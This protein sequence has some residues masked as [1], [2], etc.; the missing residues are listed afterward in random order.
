[1][2][3]PEEFLNFLSQNDLSADIYDDQDLIERYICLCPG[4]DVELDEILADFPSGVEKVTESPVTFYRLA[5]P[6]P[7]N[8]VN[9][10]V[11][12]Q[13]S[14]LIALDLASGMAVKYLEIKHG[15]HVLDLCCAPG[16]KLVLAGFLAGSTGS[17]TG[18]DISPH[19]I[20]T[21]R[22]IVKKYKLPKVR[23]FLSDGTNFDRR[24]TL[25][26]PTGSSLIEV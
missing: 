19:R 26:D 9:S 2:N 3:F 24:L 21:T 23:L 25:P 11:L 5:K 6:Y 4:K 18:V 7:N 22:S 12:Y 16:S 13:R 20:A 17:V 1:M 10:S 8:V 15:D 14:K